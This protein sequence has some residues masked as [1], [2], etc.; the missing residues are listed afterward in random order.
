MAPTQ[1]QRKKQKKQQEGSRL[2]PCPVCHRSF[3]HYFIHDHVNIC[4]DTPQI[5]STVHRDRLSAAP[6]SPI[7]R[8][9][10]SRACELE[11]E[12]ATEDEG[13]V[14]RE[15]QNYAAGDRGG[16]GDAATEEESNNLQRIP[17]STGFSPL[18][19]GFAER[20]KTFESMPGMMWRENVTCIENPTEELGLVEQSCAVGVTG[21]CEHA[22]TEESKNLQ[23]IHQSTGFSAMAEGFV[24]GVKT[25]ESMA[26]MVCREDD[27]SSGN[28]PRGESTGELGV[29]GQTSSTLWRLGDVSTKPGPG[30]KFVQVI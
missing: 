13:V 1:S 8:D 17:Q 10:V 12:R 21:D 26:S 30:F 22:V 16:C 19:E 24:A 11:N 18:A 2:L 9:C 20:A 25:F 5:I 14:G 28:P 7:S 15:P 4:L 3:P 27:I 6:M 29:D 23:R